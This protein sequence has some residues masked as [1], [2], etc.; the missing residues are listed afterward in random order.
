MQHGEAC[1]GRLTRRYVAW[2]SML[3]RCNN[4]R[5]KNYK[6]YGERGIQ[7][8]RRWLDFEAFAADMGEHPGRGWTLE[9]KNTNKNYTPTNCKWATR[10]DQGRNQRSTK[11][12]VL[13]AADIRR[14]YVRGVNVN[15]RGNS[16]ALAEEY[17]VRPS[18]IRR[19]AREETWEARP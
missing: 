15:C 11:L 2:T 16:A 13:A 3:S 5:N 6:D 10:M 18:A 7:V 17:G 14:R 12:T 19:V 4:P 1:R 8:C 9:R